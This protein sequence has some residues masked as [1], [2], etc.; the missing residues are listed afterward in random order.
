VLF[1]RNM[2]AKPFANSNN[3]ESYALSPLTKG[4]E[5]SPRSAATPPL[6]PPGDAIRLLPPT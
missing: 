4:C 3:A 2:K 1:L 6:Q 5:R